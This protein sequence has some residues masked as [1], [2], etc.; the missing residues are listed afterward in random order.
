MS[1]ASRVWWVYVLDFPRAEYDPLAGVPHADGVYLR[2]TSIM[3]VTRQFAVPADSLP[4]LLRRVAEVL[5]LPHGERQSRY[6]RWITCPREWCYRHV[7]HGRQAFGPSHLPHLGLRPATP[8][9]VDVT[10]AGLWDDAAYTRVTLA[11]LKSP[12]WVEDYLLYLKL[13]ST[14]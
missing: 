14:L 11:D 6:E 8:E 12:G 7:A 2:Y 5:V 9:S 10:P 4:R 3:H 13:R 1:N